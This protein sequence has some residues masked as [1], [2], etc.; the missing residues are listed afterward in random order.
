MGQTAIY[1]TLLSALESKVSQWG[2]IGNV[3]EK[4]STSDP[5]RELIKVNAKNTTI[6]LNNSYPSS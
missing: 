6:L 2:G 1:N 5:A 3:Q 4:L